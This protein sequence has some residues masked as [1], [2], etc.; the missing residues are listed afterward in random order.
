MAANVNIKFIAIAGA[1]LTIVG[2]AGVW[3]AYDRLTRTGEESVQ[4]GDEAAAKND[5]ETAMLMYSRA[6]SKDQSK[7]EWIDKWINAVHNTRPKTSQLY[8]E[9]YFGQYVLA[10]RARADADRTDAAALR[11][12][13]DEV[14]KRITINGGDLGAWEAQLSHVDD[15]LKR[16]HG[17]EKDGKA[18]RRFRGIAQVR[19]LQQKTDLNADAARAA[20]EDLTAALEADPSDEESVISLSSLDLMAA[21]DHRRRSENEQ[22]QAREGAARKR[23]EDYV[24]AYPP[25]TSSRL[26]IFQIDMEAFARVADPGTTRAEAFRSRRDQ[27]QQIVDAALAERKDRLEPGTTLAVAELAE[28]TLDSGSNIADM[29]FTQAL[30]GRPNDPQLM[31]AWGRME[32]LRGSTEKAVERLQAL[33]DLPDPPVSLEG[34]ILLS[35]RAR[36][37]SMQ[38]DTIFAAWE[39]ATTT[40]ERESLEAR[41]KTYRK[42]MGDY[43]A[44]D[45]PMLLS[46][47]ARLKYMEGDLNAARKLL[48]DYNE[49]TGARDV[50]ALQ[51]LA[52]VLI[53]QENLGAARTN[54][55]RV[56]DLDPR[57]VRA[58]TRLSEMA[59]AERDFGKARRLLESAV[60]FAPN[61]QRL[62]ETLRTV[63]EMSM[64]AESKDPVLKVINEVRKM[65]VG[66]AP[67]LAGATAK[68]RDG[69]RANPGEPRLSRLLAELLLAQN[70][71]AGAVE[72]VRAGLAANPDH[73][74]LKQLDQALNDPDP[75][76]S[77]L[78][79]I[80]QA[81]IPDLNKN[82]D[83]YR[84][85]RAAGRTDEANAQLDAAARMDPVDPA[86]V[87]LLFMRAA[88]KNDTTEMDRL[89]VLAEAKNLDQSKGM[90]FRARRDLVAL[91]KVPKAEARRGGMETVAAGLRTALTQDRLN[92][93]LWRML[94]IVQL[95]LGQARA[96]AESFTRAVQIRPG[97]L[98][99]NTSL[100]KAL[101]TLKDYDEALK[102]ARRA[103]AQCGRDPEFAKL[104]LMLESEGPG[105]DREKALAA[106]R[107]IAASQPD[108]LEN[109]LSLV[110]LLLGANLIEEAEPLAAEITSK[111][112]RLGAAARA[113]ILARR[114]DKT[115]AVA[116]YRVYLDTVTD[117][118]KVGAEYV[119][120]ANF[121]SQVAGREQAIALLE[122]ARSKQDPVNREIDRTIGDLYFDAGELDKAVTAYEQVLA[123][124]A[125]DE[126][127]AVMKRVI[128]CYLRRSKFQQAEELI[129]S[130]GPRAKTDAVLLILS[131]QSMA[132]QNNMEGARRA[133]D[134]AVA[135]EPENYLVY[136]KRAEFTSMD[137]TLSRDTEADLE[138]SLKLR[139]DLTS[140]R[141]MLASMYFASARTDQGIDQIRKALTATPGDVALRMDFVEL[142]LALTRTSEALDLLEDAIKQFPEDLQWKLRAASVF[143]KTNRFERAS[144]LVGEIFAKVPTPEV[145]ELY[146]VS[147]TSGPNPNP[148]RAMEVLKSPALNTDQ[149]SRLLMLRARV[150]A[151][152]KKATEALGDATL[153]WNKTDQT[154]PEDIELYFRTFTTV[155]ESPKDQAEALTQMERRNPFTG[156][157][158]YRASIIRAKIPGL[159]SQATS[160]FRQLAET[161][162]PDQTLIAAA[163]SA[164]GSAAYRNKDFDN[165][166]KAFQRALVATPDDAEL[167]NNVAYTL[168]IELKRPAEALPFA[169]SA[170][171]AA[172]SSPMILDTLGA[173]YHALG[174][175]NQARP[176]LERAVNLSVTPTE[177]VPALL[178]LAATIKALGDRTQ[179]RK[180]AQMAS[181]FLDANPYLKDHYEAELKDLLQ[182]LDGQ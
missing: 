10:L 22:V 119:A 85:L 51:L 72:A 177:R 155:F 109:K 69:L 160:A 55:E 102:V 159:E 27:V 97:D 33:I 31:L 64:G 169:E 79:A 52:E 17:D 140:A 19:L 60:K 154:K 26:A 118:A 123:G 36:A 25:A 50:L 47:D 95:D 82:L 139:P 92:P 147:L 20:V 179:A 39:R 12:Y 137:P 100:I 15:M 80:D 59:M 77:Q 89:C 136:F 165:A 113:A 174:K 168:G 48:S 35:F 163:W 71:R 143:T 152:A 182:S 172:P 176:V 111:D 129:N 91:S 116:A 166:L 74:T 4:L 98:V 121:L 135:A 144:Q 78:R 127:M 86:V 75:V 157:A 54:Y 40:E 146:V 3:Y 112:A 84:V 178:H 6:V 23:L 38:A 44:A 173:L 96:A 58:M 2:A 7:V 153:A 133:L 167:N 181:Q 57:S 37:V 14:H 9:R 29:L 68:V 1:V 149:S 104:L 83:R 65:T 88:E 142:L 161:P 156:W 107:R 5:W 53:R 34:V 66:V 49:Q 134:Q 128:E 61:D 145:A 73:P 158:L 148:S 21:A 141:R 87:E 132:G 99:S 124:G 101:L 117:P 42:A 43:V 56:L 138:Q 115:G 32:M 93:A 28:I 41:A 24:K 11:R 180:Y 170:A 16:F 108:D 62:K 8:T 131:A 30:Q 106:R 162:G 164:L 70:D 125:P 151:R 67:D 46:V 171:R 122:T 94:G 120:A 175:E 114:G 63:T 105:G 126:G 45:N 18:L 90:V 130:L 76:N 150:W 103:E 81:N 110:S 13:L